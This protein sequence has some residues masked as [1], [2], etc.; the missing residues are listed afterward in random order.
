MK[1][2]SIIF[3]SYFIFANNL[4]A[5]DSFKDLSTTPSNYVDSQL[6]Q[7]L[8]SKYSQKYNDIY[9]KNIFNNSNSIPSVDQIYSELQ[10]P[11]G[12]YLPAQ[13]QIKVLKLGLC[14]K[15]YDDVIFNLIQSKILQDEDQ[16]A[17]FPRNVTG[18]SME[19]ETYLTKKLAIKKISTKNSKKSKMN[20][21]PISKFSVNALDSKNVTVLERLYAIY[22][23][24]Q[25]KRM[26]EAMNL[27]LNVMD[28]VKVETTIVFRA[29]VGRENYVVE[30]TP[31]DI[32]R[33]AVRLFNMEKKKLI[34]DNN[35]QNLPFTNLD[36]LASAYEMG[37]VSEGE[38]AILTNDESFYRKEKSIFKKI[39][40]YLGSL[41]MT[42]AQINPMT[43]PYAIVGLILYN[44][45]QEINNGQDK[46][47]Y[48]NFYF[49]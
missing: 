43:A 4:V 48:D 11:E 28:A 37:I 40:N 33:L 12:S 27:V 24:E 44:S 13:E 46:I 26:A 20:P 16:L 30:H 7:K 36:I 32:Y 45:Y 2:L 47:E 6:C 5:D 3:M 35:N 18:P 41:G 8:N 39:G 9:F 21:F 10:T 19:L 31:S 23:P 29:D 42:A 34:S 25:I 15:K 49:N 38:I 14:Q 1:V 22:T 17:E